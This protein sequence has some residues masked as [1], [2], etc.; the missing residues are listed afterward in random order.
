MTK[1]SAEVFMDAIEL[2]RQ[3]DDLE[4]ALRHLVE[5]LDNLTDPLAQTR[6]VLYWSSAK[7]LLAELNLGPAE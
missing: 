7:L 5:T 6:L 2:H 4:A 3:R 1:P